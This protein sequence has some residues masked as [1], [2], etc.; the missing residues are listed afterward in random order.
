MKGS[1]GDRRSTNLKLVLHNRIAMAG[2]LCYTFQEHPLAAFSSIFHFNKSSHHH[3]CQLIHGALLVTNLGCEIRKR[4]VK[5]QVF[6]RI[7]SQDLPQFF[8]YCSFSETWPSVHQEYMTIYI[9]GLR[10]CRHL[11]WMSGVPRWDTKKKI[12][13]VVGLGGMP[14]IGCD[15][16]LHGVWIGFWLW[17][18]VPLVSYI[19]GSCEIG[20]G[21]LDGL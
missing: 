20:L 12:I 17:T 13:D 10:V 9:L 3:H 1:G 8:R 19:T 18:W 4:I 2:S 11:G 21:H 7:P 14:A 5:Y 16:Q 15:V 6:R